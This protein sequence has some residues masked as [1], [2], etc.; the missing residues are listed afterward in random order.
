MGRDSWHHDFDQAGAAL[1]D[2]V[3]QAIRAIAEVARRSDDVCAGFFQNSVI[4]AVVEDKR[5]GG[6]RNTGA[7]QKECDGKSFP[8]CGFYAIIALWNAAALRRI[9][10]YYDFSTQ[11]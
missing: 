4:G 2:C 7:L 8:P 6:L 3:R 9:H 1:E 11:P 10:V 5:H